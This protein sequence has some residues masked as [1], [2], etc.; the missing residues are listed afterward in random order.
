MTA[1]LERQ[2]VEQLVVEGASDLPGA[3]KYR[4]PRPASRQSL[5]VT[6]W[7]RPWLRPGGE[8]LGSCSG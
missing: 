2:L 3:I 1:V 8:Q 5:Q 6:S 7:V 4:G